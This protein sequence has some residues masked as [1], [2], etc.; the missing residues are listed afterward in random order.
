MVISPVL[1]ES[2]RQPADHS[3]GQRS[4]EL[5]NHHLLG[6]IWRVMAGVTGVFG[7]VAIAA[8]LGTGIDV[9]GLLMTALAAIVVAALL[10]RYPR[11]KV[12]RRAELGALPLSGVIAR[13]ELWLEARQPGL[14][15]SSARIVDHMGILLDA[16]ALELDRSSEGRTEAQAARALVTRDLPDLVCAYLDAQAMDEARLGNP[17]AD[18]DR[19]NDGLRAISRQI[20]SFTRRMAER[21]G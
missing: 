13:T 3:I 1:A 20:V 17:Q 12:P 9:V 14:P 2:P 8:V 18:E 15:P 6:R 11:L 5:K 10:L 19:L 21:P 7:M 4:R 16:L